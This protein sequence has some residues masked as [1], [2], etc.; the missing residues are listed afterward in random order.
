MENVLDI[1]KRLYDPKDPVV[2]VDETNKQLVKEN[3][4]P[5]PAEPGQVERYDYEYERGSDLVVVVA[6]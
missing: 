2:C 1:Y 3:K 6:A 4:M 5:L